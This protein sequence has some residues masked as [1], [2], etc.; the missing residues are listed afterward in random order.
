[1]LGALIWLSSQD[2]HVKTSLTVSFQMEGRFHPEYA[3]NIGTADHHHQHHFLVIAAVGE[4]WSF[5]CHYHPHSTCIKNHSG[6]LGIVSFA[7]WDNDN[8]TDQPAS[9]VRPVATSNRVSTLITDL[10]HLLLLPR[11]SSDASCL[12]RLVC[13]TVIATATLL[14]GRHHH[15]LVPTLRHSFDSCALLCA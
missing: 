14:F 3:Q 8:T 12:L 7:K 13:A 4:V 1:M 5:A 9:L 2:A 10:R 15:D 6:T 11:G